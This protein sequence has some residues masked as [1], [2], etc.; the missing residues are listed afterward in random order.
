MDILEKK[1]LLEV[2]ELLDFNYGDTT[3]LL[4]KELKFLEDRGTAMSIQ[5]DIGKSLEEKK[6]KIRKALGW[7]DTLISNSF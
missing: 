3:N 2:K 5:N 4:S 1:V 6:E 7:I